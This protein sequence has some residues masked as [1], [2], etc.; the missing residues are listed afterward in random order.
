MPQTT[1]R[2][3][4]SGSWYKN[5]GTELLAGI[6]KWLAAVPGDADCKARAVISP[7]AGHVYCG[8]VM[9]HAYKHL[10]TS[11]SRVFVLGPSHH[12]YTS[13]C[14]L[15]R[16]ETYQTPIGDIQIDQQVCR[17]LE[18][19][20]LFDHMNSSI[21]EAEHSLELQ[22]PFIHATMR[23]KSYT[24]IPIM[25]G[26]LTVE[27]EEMFGRV[28]APYLDDPANVFVISSDFCHWGS[29]FSYT[30]YDPS[31]GQIHE[32]IEKLD[33]LGMDLIEQGKPQA[34]AAYLKQY[35]NTICGRH[36]I[37]VFL[38]MLQACKTRCADG[39]P[40]LG[41]YTQFRLGLSSSY[42]RMAQAFGLKRLLQANSLPESTAP[43]WLLGNKYEN[44]EQGGQHL[45][46]EVWSAIMSDWFSRVWITY[47]EG[48]PA[49][50]GTCTSDVGWGCTLRTGQMMLAQALLQHLVGRRWRRPLDNVCPTEV[51][52]I[53][54]WFLDDPAPQHAFSIHSLCAA[55]QGRGITV[56]QWL[57]PSTCCHALHALVSKTKPGGLCTHIVSSPGGGAPVL[58]SSRVADL[59]L[60]DPSEPGSSKGLL[61]FVPLVLGTG[62]TLNA[63][64]IP[65]LQQVLQWQQ[66]AGI[67]GGRPGSSLYFV[68]CQDQNVLF[69]D[70]H[71]LQQVVTQDSELGTY[72]CDQLR[73][74]PLANMDPSLALGFY[75]SGAD[76]FAD[77]CQRLSALERQSGG[78]P[79][80]C[81][82][83]GQG[84]PAWETSLDTPISSAAGSP[85]AQKGGDWE[86]L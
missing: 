13:K 14:M 54:H 12:H 64:Y 82:V 81:V 79:L 66:S 43:M 76:D 44:A 55:G 31:M 25:V 19:T 75:C 52:Q 23:H 35:H 73:C 86:F 46:Q 5:S 78:A 67:V 84:E 70:P 32:C 42:Y 40:K 2:A 33:R 72:F 34:F 11:A 30:Y 53:L 29:R 24:L 83:E 3:S 21:D 51:A 36:P 6:E 41:F 77:L 57:G 80:L 68:G 7:H 8:H 48:F 18:A 71:T 50:Q 56:G 74:M 10:D 1:R 45:S 39:L 47:R 28:L 62:K 22:L 65:Q 61:L 37:G 17:D 16:A 63:R 85:S 58:Y 49:I 27:S 15:S 38:N 59:L 69:L 26:R 4:H 60:L 9:A 20:G